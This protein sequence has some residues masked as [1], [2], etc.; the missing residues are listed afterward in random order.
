MMKSSNKGFT[1][2]ELLLAFAILAFC[3]C[4]ILLTYIN[5]FLLSDL[6][7]DL[8]LTTNAVQAKTEEIKKTPFDNLLSL[9]GTTFNLNPF[10]A[11]DAK[12][13]IEVTDTT[14]SDL[15]RVRVIAAFKSRLRL[16][17][18]DKNLNGVL[19][20]GED[21]DNNGALYWPIEV[22]TFIAR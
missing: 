10:P 17:G 20:P 13:F 14:Y 19:D 18:E 2:I 9:N 3:L 21:T 4:G 5:M 8:T 16:I 22:V 15:K 6:S 7:R 12:G 1:L 11:S